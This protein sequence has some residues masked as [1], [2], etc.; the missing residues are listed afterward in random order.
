MTN[1]FIE[2][3]NGVYEVKRPGGQLGTRS[4]ILLSHMSTVE[5]IQEVPDADVEDPALI[6]RI[7]ASNNRIAMA[8]MTEVFAEWAPEMLPNIVVSGPFKYDDMPDTDQLAI[9]VAINQESLTGD[10]L[11][12]I[13]PAKPA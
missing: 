7:K 2:T 3:K 1:M 10:D 9:F 12:R 11:F 13:L 4:M 6:A 8:K 5:G